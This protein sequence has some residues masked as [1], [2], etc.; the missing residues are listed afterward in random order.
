ML[1]AAHLYDVAALCFP[2][3]IL[4][5]SN[6]KKVSWLLFLFKTGCSAA[7]GRRGPAGGVMLCR[8]SG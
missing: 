8:P 2:L 5:F 7:S 1:R 6:K 3:Y 4:Q